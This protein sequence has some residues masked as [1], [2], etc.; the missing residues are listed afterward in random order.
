MAF[1]S[2]TLQKSPVPGQLLRQAGQ[3]L[4]EEFDRLCE[5]RLMPYVF[6]PFFFLLIFAVESVQKIGRQPLSPQFWLIMS[7]LITAYSG[8]QIFRLRPRLRRLR[9]GERGERRVAEILDRIRGKGFVAYHDLQEKGFNIDHVVVGP[10]G[11]Y[12]IETK[13][14]NV[15][16]SRTINY[17]GENDLVIGGK[18]TLG[19]PLQGARGSARAVRLQLEE[20]LHERYAVKALL[21]F[22]GDWRI[23][24][25]AIDTD[26]DIITANRLENYL[27]WQQPELTR[28]EIER[29]CSHLERSARG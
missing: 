22:L 29:V 15:F 20:H 2:K 24:R 9:Q 28:K 21:V 5:D 6:I 16:G 25:E 7:I 14:W 23:N 4:R 13:A 26:V 11:I 27:E 10:T 18:I 17:F 19:R 1:T 8:F 12:A 3:S